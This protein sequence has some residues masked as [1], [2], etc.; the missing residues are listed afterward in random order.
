[1]LGNHV[2]ALDRHGRAL[3]HAELVGDQ[4]AIQM[5]AVSLVRAFARAGRERDMLEAAGV[6]KALAAERS[7][8]GE[9][10]SAAFAEPERAVTSAI[11]RL[12]PPA[13]SIFDAGRSLEPGQRVKRLCALIYAE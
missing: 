1:M 2:E 7:A 11:E 6:A 3:T 10:V 9:F 13:E 12:G 8:H 5:L 4:G